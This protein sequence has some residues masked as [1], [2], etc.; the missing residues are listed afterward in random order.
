[1]KAHFDNLLKRVPDLLSRRSLDLGSGTG[2]F[3]IEC[4]KR[5]CSAVGLEL[6]PEK[7]KEAETGAQEEGVNIEIVT[8]VAENLPFHDEEF[9]FINVSEVIEHV[10]IPEKVLKEMNRVL[11]PGGLAY[12]SVHNR[13]GLHDAH[14]QIY[15]LGWMPRSMG[16]KYLRLLKKDKDYQSMPDRQRISE[17]HYYSYPHFKRLAE[18]AGFKSK[19]LRQEK[20]IQ[21]LGL[22]FGSFALIPYWLVLRPFFSTFHYLLKK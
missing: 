10:Q 14:F 21:K 11:K 8:G 4:G 22:V 2:R 3:L 9:D 5:G 16:E 6:N 13:Y 12:V 15:F 20:I 1:M 18:E 7:V 19:D 17:M